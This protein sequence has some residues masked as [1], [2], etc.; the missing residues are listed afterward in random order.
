M[1]AKVKRIS[2]TTAFRFSLLFALLFTLLAGSAMMTIYH[3]AHREI[4]EQIDSRLVSEA[5]RLKRAF[6]SRNTL[7]L[8]MPLTGIT[9]YIQNES[10]IIYCLTRISKGAQPEENETGT[11]NILNVRMGDLCA[12]SDEIASQKGKKLPFFPDSD[13]H[14]RVL[15]LATQNNY[16]L[17]VGY[18]TKNEQ[19]ILRR[20]LRMT[21]IS[22]ALI[23][24][25][26]VCAAFSI[27]QAIINSIIRIARVAYSFAD[28]NLSKRIHMR[29]SD[30]TEWQILAEVINHMLDKIDMLITSQRQVTNNIAHDLRSPLNRLR[31]RME[32]ALIDRN[33]STEEL[34]DVVAD[35]IEDTENLLKTFNALLSIAQVES[36]ARDD[37]SKQN[38]SAICID[39]AEMYEVIAEN[40][41][42]EF[43]CEDIDP[44]LQVFGNRQLL[45]QAITNLLDNA[46][47]YTPNGGTITL[48]AYKSDDEKEAIISVADNGAGIPPEEFEHVMERFVRLDAA[49]STPGN[50]LGLSLV[51]AIMKLHLGRITLE[52][53]QPGLNISLHFPLD[54]NSVHTDQTPDPDS[55]F[56]LF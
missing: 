1:L 55:D 16:H 4:F 14:L 45:A 11:P 36:R 17:I 37:F 2:K 10:N 52:D 44:E 39:L 9:E 46:I 50:G 49:R 21:V 54:E 29:P 26:A 7:D 48:R 32:V 33:R 42:H 51:Q 20:M 28:G 24:L 6:N 3:Y 53:N 8:Y 5:L 13:N 56:D 15:G 23:A 25:V 30:S 31:S 18:D 27:G 47:K 12:L 34:R 41:A 35:S 43:I 19:R 40:G 22:T 38:L